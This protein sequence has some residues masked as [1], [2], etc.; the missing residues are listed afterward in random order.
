MDIGWV[1]LDSVEI[2]CKQ[3]MQCK[4]VVGKLVY[5]ES[6]ECLGKA[7]VGD[8]CPPG[9]DELCHR[10]EKYCN[11]D[12][13]ILVL[14][15]MVMQKCGPQV[16]Q[17]WEMQMMGKVE[18][19]AVLQD[20]YFQPIVHELKYEWDFHVEER[21]HDQQHYL[22]WMSAASNDHNF[23]STPET[24]IQMAEP[25]QGSWREIIVNFKREINPFSLSY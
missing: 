23:H 3:V 1:L 9:F 25:V 15:Y 8:L 13:V 17:Y 16:Q 22:G 5:I 10:D 20:V 11:W 6:V 12:D 7:V 21:M 14:R 18:L 2:L 19:Q 24:Q 4:N